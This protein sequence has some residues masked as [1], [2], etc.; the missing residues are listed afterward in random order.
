VTDRRAALGMRALVVSLALLGACN[1]GATPEPRPDRETLQAPV[2]IV[3][4]SEITYKGQ[5]IDTVESELRFPATEAGV[6]A[7]D[8][9]AEASCSRVLQQIRSAVFAYDP[10]YL[11]LAETYAPK[12][13][14]SCQADGWPDNLKRCIVDATPQAL[15]H[16]HA[17][18]NLVTSELT[19]K[20][21]KRFGVS[22]SGLSFGR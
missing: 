3:T 15:A 11:S 17:C 21:G 6:R 20:V 1:R 10:Q 2:V 19:A 7:P 8:A 12:L 4:K 9:V 22:T 13:L 16:E 18:E 14:V 5:L